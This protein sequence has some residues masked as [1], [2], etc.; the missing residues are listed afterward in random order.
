MIVLMIEAR[1]SSCDS[2]ASP[3]RAAVAIERGD[4]GQRSDLA[5]AETSQFRQFGNQGAGDPGSDARNADQ[6]VHCLAP[7][8]PHRIVA[9]IA[10]VGVN[11][12]RRLEV[13]GMDIGP[14]EAEPFW[15]GAA[16]PA[17]RQRPGVRLAGAAEVERRRALVTA[18]LGSIPR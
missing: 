11:A 15:T 5:S 1:P 2:A 17:L 13:L 9:I 16:L 8:R 4:A 3:Q 7:G 12:D 10:A 14:S 6:K 18:P